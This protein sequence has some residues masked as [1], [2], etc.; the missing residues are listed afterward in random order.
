MVI[1]LKCRNLVSFK[2][3]NFQLFCTLLIMCDSSEIFTLVR[4]LYYSLAQA[5]IT[6]LEALP[7]LNAARLVIFLSN[8]G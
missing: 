4:M 3:K 8:S 5:V 6:D 2:S 1:I 7:S